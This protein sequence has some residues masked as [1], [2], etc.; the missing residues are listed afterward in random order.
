[1]VVVVLVVRR[2]AWQA[3]GG[4]LRTTSATCRCERITPRRLLKPIKEELIGN[5]MANVHA[6]PQVGFPVIVDW[7]EDDENDRDAKG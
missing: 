4:W 5:I 1:M 6:L 3:G 2:M 7:V